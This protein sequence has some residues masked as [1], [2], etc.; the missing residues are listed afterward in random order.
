[1]ARYNLCNLSVVRR[2]LDEHGLAPKKGFGQNF[3]VNPAVPEDIADAS[4]YAPF[5]YRENETEAAC[6][7]EIGPGLGALTQELSARYDRVTAVEIDRGLIPVLAETLADCANT[8]VIEGDFME[9]DVSALLESEFGESPVHVCGNL[10]YYI[11][12]PILMRL[13]EAYPADRPTP[14]KRI[15]LMVQSEVADRICAGIGDKDC[16]AITVAVALRGVAVKRFTVS[17]GNFYPVPKVSSA[18][19][20]IET[21]PHGLY[22][23]YPEAPKG[24]AF[25]PFFATVT[26]LVELAYNQRRKTLTN[27]LG[28]AF[29]KVKV[30]QALTALGLRTDIRGEKLGAKDFCALAKFLTEAQP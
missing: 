4:A 5:S 29:E 18:V 12:T 24:E 17:A 20:T 15:T 22:D 30:E 23:L 1:M 10:P 13:L 19:L 27:A 16:G 8:K 11:T 25:Q 6:A 21:Y 14:I 26:K 7:L 28:G 3:L 9:T 2:L